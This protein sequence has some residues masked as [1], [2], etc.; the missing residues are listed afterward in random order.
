MS[1]PPT[2][3]RR[4]PP[5]TQPR[6]SSDSSTASS[7]SSL[8]VPRTPRFAEATAVYSPVDDKRSPFADPPST[9]DSHA[10][11]SQ[12]Y[13]AQSQP[14]DIGFG[15]ISDN[16]RQ[17][18]GVPVEMPLTPSSPLKSA[19]RVPGTPGRM[20]N[21]LSPTFRE[22]QVLEKHEEMTEKEQVKDLKVKTRVRVAKLL[23]RFVNFSCS[24]IV[25]AMISTSV[26][27]FNATKSLPAR[28]NLPPWAEG[29][30]TWPQIVVLSVSC[31]S[32]ALC[33]VVFY[34]YWKGGHKR[35]EKVA[36]YYTLFAVAYFIFSTVMWAVAA[37]ILQGARNSGNNKDIW[38]WSCVDN[39]RREIFQEEVDYALVCRLQSWGLVCCIIEVVL[40]SITIAI[41]GVVFYRYYSK[42]RLRKSMAIRDRARSDLYLAQLRSQS[43][44][45]TPGFGPLSP[46]YSQYAKSPKFPPSAYQNGPDAEEGHGTRFVEAKPYGGMSAAKPFTLQAPPIK[47]QSATPKMDQGGFEAQTPPP[48]PPQQ[49]Q[50]RVVEHVDAA[51]GEQTYASVPIPGAYAS[52]LPNSGR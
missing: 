28:S 17:S 30:K 16:Q 24:L 34:N 48:P 37:G 4:P 52:P 51:P 49:Q 46:S 14:S 9:S 35:A 21:P 7:A 23:L 45:N 2:N 29:T 15:Y 38:G 25:L 5:L 3:K 33:L 6:S 39:K 26:T 18:Q 1:S 19:L 36:V 12:A 8:K 31:V 43:A 10:P 44:P 20:M 41:Y 40:E 42:Q 13:M 50:Q 47:V 32:L 11:K 22:E 27:I